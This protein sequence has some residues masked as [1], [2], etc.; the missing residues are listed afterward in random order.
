MMPPPGLHLRSVLTILGVVTL[1][2]VGAYYFFID[3]YS[4][5]YLQFRFNDLMSAASVPGEI[6]DATYLLTPANG[7]GIYHEGAL[8]YEE[9]ERSGSFVLDIAYV[10]GRTVS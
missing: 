7:G 6:S 4:S 2:G 8:N 5:R 9:Y 1:I 10:A 3:P